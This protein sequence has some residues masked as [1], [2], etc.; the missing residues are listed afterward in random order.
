MIKTKKILIVAA[1]YYPNITNKLILNSKKTLDKSKKIR[2]KIKI[3]L[4]P[5]VFEIPVIISKN[6]NKFDGFIALGCIIKGKTAHFNLISQSVSWGIMDL[7][8][9]YKKPIGNGIISCFNMKQAIERSRPNNKNKG[10]ESANA[11]LSVL[12]KFSNS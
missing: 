12:E 8:I 11:L 2:N 9:K 7:S 1:N 6:I 10:S 5:G 4:S 3:I